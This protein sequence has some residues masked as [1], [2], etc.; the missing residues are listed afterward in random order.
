MRQPQCRRWPTLVPAAQAT[1]R[2]TALHAVAAAHAVAA[3]HA[4]A[5][6]IAVVTVHAVV[7][8]SP[9]GVRNRSSGRR[10]LVRW[11]QA[12]V[13]SL[14]AVH[15]AAAAH[16]V[17]AVQAVAT[18]SRRR[19]PEQRP[20]GTCRRLA[21]TPL[22][23]LGSQPQRLCPGR[24]A[25]ASSARMRCRRDRAPDPGRSWRAPAARTMDP[26]MR[27]AQARRATHRPHPCV[28]P[29]PRHPPAPAPNRSMLLQR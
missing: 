7:D 23:R 26:S 4:L 6:P 2:T 9:C 17:A 5:A 15:A 24:P 18:A 8:R 14:A 27:G 29:A 22:G 12:A 13:H 20:R 16:P 21:G 1:N 19:R 10:P 3:V 28:C 11:P 25:A